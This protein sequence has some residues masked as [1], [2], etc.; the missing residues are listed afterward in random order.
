MKVEPAGLEQ[1]VNGLEVRRVIGGADMLEH[2]DRGDLV[3]IALDQRI[4]LQF[5][6]YLF[7]ESEARD[8]VLGVGEL[9]LGERHPERVDAEMPGGVTD[10]RAPAAAYV[11]QA[12]ARLQAELLADHVELV[13]LRGCQIVVPVAEVGAAVDQLGIEKERIERVGK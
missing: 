3:E 2:A 1:A 7:L 12:I 6:G 8:L 9:L 11:E 13:V 5:N 10:E 4:V